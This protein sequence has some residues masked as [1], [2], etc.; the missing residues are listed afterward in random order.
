MAG[1]GSVLDQN[2]PVESGRELNK[3]DNVYGN[4]TRGQLHNLRFY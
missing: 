3:Q 1:K 2:M 4:S